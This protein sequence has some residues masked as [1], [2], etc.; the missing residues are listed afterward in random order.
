MVSSAVPQ[1]FSDSWGSPVESKVAILAS[2]LSTIPCAESIQN[3]VQSLLVRHMKD[4]RNVLGRSRPFKASP[5][6]CRI[7][8]TCRWRDNRLRSIFEP[9]HQFHCSP[10]PC[11][12][13]FDAVCDRN[14]CSKRIREGVGWI[15]LLKLQSAYAGC[16]IGRVLEPDRLP[17]KSCRNT[18]TAPIHR[19]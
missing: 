2:R 3:S 12:A 8:K 15:K 5:I 4:D 14:P 10:P 1:P 9:K 11:S 13:I 18:G 19:R 17:T 16:L 6:C 7:S